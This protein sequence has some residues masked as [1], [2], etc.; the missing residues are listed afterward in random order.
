MG[1]LI[2]YDKYIY[3]EKLGKY[4]RILFTGNAIK[5]SSFVGIYLPIGW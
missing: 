2:G 4:I 1:V 5:P 3:N